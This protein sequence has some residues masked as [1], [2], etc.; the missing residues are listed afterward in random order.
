MHTPSE[1]KLNTVNKEIVTSYELTTKVS[2]LE[3]MTLSNFA[4]ETRRVG[5]RMGVT[6]RPKSM[7]MG[8]IRDFPRPGLK[9]EVNF[10]RVQAACWSLV[11]FLPRLRFSRLHR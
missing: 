7:C 5:V 10:Y 9:T 4:S 6:D 2:A 8:L 11:W 3:R 1:K